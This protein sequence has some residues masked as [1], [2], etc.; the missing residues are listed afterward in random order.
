MLRILDLIC[1]LRLAGW[2]RQGMRR[3]QYKLQSALIEITRGS[4]MWHYLTTNDLV[5]D[6]MK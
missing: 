6:R 1:L 5:Y 3:R 4:I 2:E